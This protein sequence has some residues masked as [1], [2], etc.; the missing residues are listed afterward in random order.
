MAN[1]CNEIE[2][3]MENE[4]DGKQ[5]GAQPERQRWQTFGRIFLVNFTTIMYEFIVCTLY[6]P[7]NIGTLDRK[8]IRVH[9]KSNIETYLMANE[10]IAFTPLQKGHSE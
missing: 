8:G 4:M 9:F 2:R 5:A 3:E 10:T 6:S 1:I 7:I